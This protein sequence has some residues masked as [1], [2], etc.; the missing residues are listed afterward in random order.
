M[1]RACS[2]RWFEAKTLSG[3]VTVRKCNA[4]PRYVLWSQYGLS[5]SILSCA[6]ISF[7]SDISSC[8]P[9]MS[10]CLSFPPGFA[11]SPPHSLGD[12]KE[13]SFLLTCRESG[14]LQGDGIRCRF[15]HETGCSPSY[16]P[17]DPLQ[18]PA[19]LVL[20]SLSPLPYAGYRFFSSPL[21]RSIGYVA[22]PLAALGSHR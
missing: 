14:S 22:L 9:A 18:S 4:L 3:F 21:V 13:S 20:L 15:I 16:Q 11:F 17:T 5:I 10:R 6:A 7:F 1:L 12:V 8:F 2:S 19:A